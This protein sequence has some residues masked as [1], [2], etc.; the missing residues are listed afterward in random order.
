MAAWITK[1]I[2]QFAKVVS[3]ATPSTSKSEYWNGN[4]VWIT[5]NDLSKTNTPFIQDSER[6]I[7]ELGLQNCS[8]QIIPGGNLVISYRAPIGY[9]AIVNSDFTTNQGC[10]SIVFNSEHCPLFHYYNFLFRINEFKKMGEG[11]TFAEISKKEIEKLEFTFPESLEEQTLIANFFL[12][13]DESLLKSEEQFSKLLRIKN[14]AM[15]D[16]LTG[17]LRVDKLL[18]SA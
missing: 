1:K 15:Q 8:A 14:G 18:K 17:R 6:K 16:I 5:P 9:L 11:T 7:S 3:G 2:S 4:I 13:L 12:T 10:K